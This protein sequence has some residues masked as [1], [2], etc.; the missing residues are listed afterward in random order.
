MMSTADEPEGS[1]AKTSDLVRLQLEETENSSVRKTGLAKLAKARDISDKSF[2]GSDY[3]TQIEGQLITTNLTSN[4]EVSPLRGLSK[5]SGVT[6]LPNKM[7]LSSLNGDSSSCGDQRK[8]QDSS[9]GTEITVSD[10]SQ[11]QVPCS[12]PELVRNNKNRSSMKAARVLGFGTGKDPSPLLSRRSRLEPPKV[13]RSNSLTH[14]TS[15][16]NQMHNMCIFAASPAASEVSHMQS[17]N[18]SSKSS[19]KA[20]LSGVVSEVIDHSILLPLMA[21]NA[22]RTDQVC[23]SSPKLSRQPAFREA[24]KLRNSSVDMSIVQSEDSELATALN[25]SDSN[26]V[27]LRTG[28]KNVEN[29]ANHRTNSLPET[30]GSSINLEE[31]AVMNAFLLGSKMMIPS[32]KSCNIT[33][34]KA[35][36]DP[37][38]L[39]SSVAHSNKPPT[40]SCVENF[41][42]SSIRRKSRKRNCDTLRHVTTAPQALTS[43]GQ[44]SIWNRTFDGTNQSGRPKSWDDKDDGECSSTISSSEGGLHSETSPLAGHR[45]ASMDELSSISGLPPI[46]PS[47]AKQK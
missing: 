1:A 40:P 24:L 23:T 27:I 36:S 17:R 10:Y 16:I 35:P 14:L 5:S 2:T 46:L 7:S 4:T 20:P 31:A 25:S 3:G 47:D 30:P 32:N 29:L 12:D 6:I 21:T 39:C 28:L 45:S 43:H 9:P 19:E 15:A 18:V 42:R 11:S 34:S 13:K 8:S 22:T 38:E 44:N 37:S 33:S 26:L 41:V